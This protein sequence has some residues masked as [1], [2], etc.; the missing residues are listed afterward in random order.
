V[1]AV[2]KKERITVVY[3]IDFI[4]T[5]E[6]LTG[7]TEMQLIEM[8]NQLDQARFRPIIFCLQKFVE[9]PHWDA[10]RCE[11][12]LLDVYSLVSL[13][14]VKAFLY[15]VRFLRQ[16]SVDIVQTYFHDATLFGILAAKLAGVKRAI[17]CRRD[18]GFW[19]DKTSLRNMSFVN[20]F[21]DRVLVNS[22][23]VK[24]AVCHNEHV[25]GSKIDVI[26]NGLNLEAFD[27]KPAVY[28]RSIFSEIHENDKVIGMVANFNREVK[29]ADVFIMA[30]AQVVKRY[31]DAKFL[32]IGGGKL[33]KELRKLISR[34]GLEGRVILGG[35]REPAA[36]YIKAF[37]I[38][39]LTSD[40]E[41]FSNVLLECMAGGIPV[42]ATD[43]GGNREL[44]QNGAL[45][46]LV[47]RGDHNAI[48]SGICSLLADRQKREEMGRKAR[49]LVCEHFTW[50]QK[51]REIQSY[52]E[53]F[54]R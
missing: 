40:S 37:D 28:L 47:P 23:A 6:G 33:E 29:R 5:E 8:V 19:Y 22:A 16:R 21:T 41:G 54:F 35:K 42:V 9:T 46:L 17:S 1:Q 25:A 50:P 15:F 20:K 30:A 12:H 27:R 2:R 11:K 53:E 34:F 24:E 32:L 49:R 45:G 13:Q 39:V 3:V 26:H 14:G 44:V 38:G 51:I 7:G 10:V 18:L 52:Y 43:V 31:G 48:A 4:A 36:P